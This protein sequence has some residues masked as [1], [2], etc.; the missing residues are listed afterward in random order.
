MVR[1]TVVLVLAASALAGCG[2]GSYLPLE[3]IDG[4]YKVHDAVRL[5]A[6]QRVDQMAGGNATAGTAAPLG[7]RGKATLQ[8]RVT[9]ASRATPRLAGVPISTSGAQNSVIPTE[10]GTATSLSADGAVGVWPGFR[11]GSGHLLGVD[12]LGSVSLLSGHGASDLE[13]SGGSVAVAGGVRLG[14][15]EETAS[16]PGISLS[17]VYQRLPSFSLSPDPLVTDDGEI[18]VDATSL[19]V[20]STSARIA[21]SKQWGQWGATAGYGSDLVKVDGNIRYDLTGSATQPDVFAIV[22]QETEV[23]R[24]T[25]YGGVSYR[26]GAVTISGE[27]G[28]RS[29]GDDPLEVNNRFDR[30]WNRTFAS[31][32]VRIGSR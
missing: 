18:A 2:P 28:R 7:T 17:V 1:S 24:N 9:G 13:I 12:L 4:G 21:I 31:L 14:F 8:L 15:V 26:L 11:V 22:T 29:G 3:L 25:V 10:S 5:I 6:A 23:R 30:G 32:G 16:N 19:V 27:A 20:K